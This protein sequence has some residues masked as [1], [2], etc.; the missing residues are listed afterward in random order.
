MEDAGQTEDTGVE[1][2]EDIATVR[3]KD[4]GQEEPEVTKKT[5]AHAKEFASRP[6]PPSPS[7]PLRQ[8]VTKVGGEVEADGIRFAVPFPTF[9]SVS[10]RSG[11]SVITAASTSPYYTQTN[12]RTLSI[13]HRQLIQRAPLRLPSPFSPS[14]R[15]SSHSSAVSALV[16]RRCLVETRRR[17]GFWRSF[18][19]AAEAP[20]PAPPCDPVSPGAAIAA[21]DSVLARAVGT[22][23]EHSAEL[24]NVP[25]AP[26]TT[27]SSA[28]EAADHPTAAVPPNKT[29]PATS[30]AA[31]DCVTA[32][33]VAVSCPSPA[34]P[35]S[36]PSTTRNARLPS[37]SVETSRAVTMVKD[38]GSDITTGTG[39]RSNS[40]V[41]SIS[42]VALLAAA[43]PSSFPSASVP[44]QVA[45]PSRETAPQLLTEAAQPKDLDHPLPH[46]V[47]HVAE[48]RYP[49]TSP[50]NHVRAPT[51]PPAPKVKVSPKDYELRKQ[52]RKEEKEAA[53]S[54]GG[55]GRTPGI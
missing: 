6:P 35:S 19:I 47:D 41:R 34:L 40:Q 24:L 45:L 12:R 1:E 23:S 44:A 54:G 27:D 46:E 26:A 7:P 29:S 36:T 42:G 38:V 13:S 32:E 11:D 49:P 51:P 9:A 33:V 39:V 8:R 25:A 5:A 31:V 14:Y 53:A 48:T 4:V 3:A 18:R 16:P 17:P 50:V 20:S 22:A 2:K 55:G 10:A 43:S 28:P 30:A 52:K 21:P 15:R 37:P